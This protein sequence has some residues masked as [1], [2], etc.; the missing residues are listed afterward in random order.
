MNV[1][2]SRS[3]SVDRPSLSRLVAVFRLESQVLFSVLAP[4]VEDLDSE[5]AGMRGS[6]LS[7][8]RRTPITR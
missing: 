6:M 2:F 4:Q 8:R 7:D 3:P 5:F 1:K